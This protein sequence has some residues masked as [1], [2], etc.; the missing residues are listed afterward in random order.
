MQMKKDGML[1]ARSMTIMLIPLGAVLEAI[2]GINC[3]SHK[4][5]NRVPRIA[6]RD[7]SSRFGKAVCTFIILNASNESPEKRNMMDQIHAQKIDTYRRYRSLTT[8]SNVYIP[9]A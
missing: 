6:K 8:P 9:Y 1:K 2:A 5:G 7:T 3:V 4:I